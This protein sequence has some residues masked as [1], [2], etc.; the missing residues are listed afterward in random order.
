VSLRLAAICKLIS[1]AEAAA[2]V[3]PDLRASA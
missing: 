3:H 1:Q 2:E